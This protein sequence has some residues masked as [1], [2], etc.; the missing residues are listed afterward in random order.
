M[1][2]IRDEIAGDVVAREALLDA[3]FETSRFE[4]TSE[5]LREGR[6]PAR[7]LKLSAVLEDELVGT[8][9]LWHI[10]AGTAGGGLLLGPLAVDQDKR[11]LG[12]GSRLMR[13]ALWRAAR[14]GH[15]FVLLVGDLPYYQRFGFEHA[16]AALDLPGPV[17]RSRFLAFEIIP[18]A[19]SGACGM[20]VATGAM[21][22]ARR[23]VFA[24]QRMAA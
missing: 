23:G 18:G 22:R 19:L 17:D 14:T 2:T 21:E 3:S 10:E 16:P 4:K 6:Q 20:V 24:D 11:G 5:R 12:L 7:G 9:R 13:E 1:V 15:R 8:V